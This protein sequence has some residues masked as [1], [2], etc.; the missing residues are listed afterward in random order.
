MMSW[1]QRDPTGPT[2]PNQES[3]DLAKRQWSTIKIEFV[4]KYIHVLYIYIHVYIYIYMGRYVYIYIYSYTRIHLSIHLS[5][6]VC[7]HM[8]RSFFGTASPLRRA[9]LTFFRAPH[10]AGD[11]RPKLRALFR[12][13]TLRGIVIEKK[14][15]WHRHLMEKNGKEWK[16]RKQQI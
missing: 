1:V 7:L 16:N 11:L 2:R 15:T 12:H 14:V 5:M 8:L 10:A 3:S 13:G 9:N 6:C 4:A